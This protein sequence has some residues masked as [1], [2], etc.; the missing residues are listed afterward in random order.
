[1]NE[2]SQARLSPAG[3]QRREAML[4]ELTATM[5]IVHHRRRRRRQLMLAAVVFIAAGV[6]AKVALPPSPGAPRPDGGQLLVENNQAPRTII[7]RTEPGIIE[8]YRAKPASRVR[9]LD[10]DDLVA[11]LAALGRPAGLVRQEGRVWLTGAVT[12][13]QRP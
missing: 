2:S 11:Q 5:R 7:F 10:D 12:D 9:I 1:M 13:A 4:E 3:E 6:S 8:R